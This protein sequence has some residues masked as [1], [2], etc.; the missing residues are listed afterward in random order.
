MVTHTSM[1]AVKIPSQIDLSVLE[2]LQYGDQDLI[3]RQDRDA[4]YKTSRS[5]V[6]RIVK[7]QHR[8]DRILK[9]ALELALK[10]K[11]QFPGS[12]LKPVQHAA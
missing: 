5:Y 12:T 8:N 4:G 9:L 11:S 6:C 2:F 7:G 3:A 1:K 10:R